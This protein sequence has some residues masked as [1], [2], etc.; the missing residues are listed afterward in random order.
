[1]DDI[2]RMVEEK[3]CKETIE[4]NS[5]KLWILTY[6]LDLLFLTEKRAVKKE[7]KIA[8]T[9]PTKDSK[10]KAANKQKE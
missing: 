10:K 3:S 2:I 4:K 1:M 5:M 6:F 9:K 7:E 8:K